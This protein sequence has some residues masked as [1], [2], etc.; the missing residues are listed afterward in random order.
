[1]A[2]GDRRALRVRLAESEAS[3]RELR[4]ALERQ[5]QLL[6]DAHYRA[7]DNLQTI[8][9]FIEMKTVDVTDPTALERIKEIKDRVGTLG[10]V[11]GMLY[12]EQPEP[13]G[14]LVREIGELLQHSY[15]ADNVR[16]IYDISVSITREKAVPLALLLTE[17][18]SN[19]FKHAF[20]DTPHPE[21]IVRLEPAGGDQVRLTV[22]DNGRG[23]PANLDT[24]HRRPTGLRLVQ[25]L[26][27][28]LGGAIELRSDS[29]TVITVT[30]GA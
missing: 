5:E 8:I 3:N 4:A 7:R 24:S 1:M 12:P 14:R 21:I 30:F 10:A 17:L 2:A 15:G 26:A 19:A 25:G 28:E 9:A 27:E 11:Y 16:M 23:L 13:S 18:L 29:G 22:A 6:V 20:T